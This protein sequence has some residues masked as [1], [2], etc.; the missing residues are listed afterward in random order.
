MTRAR[1]IFWALVAIAAIATGALSKA[2]AAPPSPATGIA[3]GL[4][5]IILALALAL[6]LRILV[7]LD[8]AGH[9]DHREDP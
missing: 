3:V 1:T 6:A 7:R 4:S 5:A 8:P 2:V 9:T